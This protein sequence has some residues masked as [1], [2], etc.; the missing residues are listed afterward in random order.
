MIA[1]ANPGFVSPRLYR[2]FSLLILSCQKRLLY[3]PRSPVASTA[4]S[5]KMKQT[6]INIPLSAAAKSIHVK[7]KF[8]G[9]FCMIFHL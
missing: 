5:K 8:L 9:F 4:Q 1:L 2:S 6:E 7:M 3:S